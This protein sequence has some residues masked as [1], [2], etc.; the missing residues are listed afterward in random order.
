MV[1]RGSGRRNPTTDRHT[2]LQGNKIWGS[3]PRSIAFVVVVATVTVAVVVVDAAIVVATNQ[4]Q[5]C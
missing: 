4:V 2:E 5:C 3:G 1:E